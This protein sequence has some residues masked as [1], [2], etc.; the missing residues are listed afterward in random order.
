M[1]VHTDHSTIKYLLTKKDAKPRLIRWVLLL[2]EF[3]VEIKDKKGIEKLVADHLSRLEGPKNEVQINDNFPDEQ[4]L[5]I[6]NSSLVPRFSNYVNYLVPKV[7]PPP[8]PLE[9]TYQQKKKFFVNLKH[10]YWDES[11]LYKHY[12]DHII[13]RC[14]PE[15]EMG[16]I[17]IHYHSL[18][19][20][21]H[22]E[23]NRTTS[24]VLQL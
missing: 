14:I 10:Y 19:C 2:Q 6:S 8:P 16:N 24:K 4:L 13:R 23:G 9:F 1:I 11:F 21:G 12:V 20:G 17:L 18:D 5:T 7:T 3:D 15:E 22:F